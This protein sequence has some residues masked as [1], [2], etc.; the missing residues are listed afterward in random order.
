MPR[1][2]AIVLLLPLLTPLAA[3]AQFNFLSNVDRFELG[4]RLRAFEIAL[5]NQTD[6]KARLRA[7]KPLKNLSVIFFS[8]QLGEAARMLDRARLALASDK[9]P[10]PAQ[11]YAETL[12]IRPSS[13]LLDGKAAEL[14]LKV[15]AYYAPQGPLPARLQVRVRVASMDGKTLAG[16]V[17]LLLDGVPFEDKLPLKNLPEGDHALQS[18]VLLENKVV[19][20]W[21]Q[22]LSVVRDRDARVK[23]LEEG[24]KALPDNPSTDQESLRNLAEMLS[25][26]R[27]DKA[28][29]TNFPA[30]RLVKEAEACL[31]ALRAGKPFYG[32]KKV[33]QFWLRMPL[34][35]SVLA[36]RLQAPEAAARGEPLPLVI[37]LHGAAGSENM[38]FDGY[39]NGLVARLCAQRGWLLA[40]PRE[41]VPTPALI[42]EI[43]R[44]YPV[45]RRRVF[46]VGHSLGAASA[47]SAA[48]SY[49]DCFAAVAALGGGR[50]IKGSDA[51]KKA[52]F[53]VGCGTED[54]ALGGARSLHASLKK[55]EVAKVKYHEYPDLEHL[56]IVQ[57]ALRDV[58]AFFEEVSR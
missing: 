57:L 30:A 6:E 53:F 50:S 54:F 21:E 15:L 51:L 12:S 32:Q 29:E 41:A 39:G 13:V 45:D 9:D 4:Q 56:V 25:A 10:E 1:T 55:A 17:A 48:Q 37:A 20:R 24:V 38:M 18:E 23:A 16:P 26:L 58:F 2:L 34:K 7:I 46:V 36:L 5:E 40:A 14:P 11:L 43:A 27:R 49:P 33:G 28:Q 47:V 31:E 44:L 42:D 3:P 52:A 19:V 22:T 8:G 35:P